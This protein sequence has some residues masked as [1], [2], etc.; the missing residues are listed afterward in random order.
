M[1]TPDVAPHR[2][3][4]PLRVGTRGSPLALVQTRTF[5]AQISRFCPVLNGMDAFE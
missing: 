1:A 3:A 2:Q 5:L 4:L